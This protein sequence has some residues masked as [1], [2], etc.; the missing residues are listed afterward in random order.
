M[1]EFFC[2]NEKIFCG[3]SQQSQGKEGQGQA[4]EEQ[5]GKKSGAGPAGTPEGQEVKGGPQ[6]QNQGHE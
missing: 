6:G 1:K 4:P 2:K 3:F 5:M